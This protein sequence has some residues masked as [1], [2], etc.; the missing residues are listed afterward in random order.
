VDD[1]EQ[2]RRATRMM[3]EARG[4]TVTDVAGGHAALKLAQAGTEWEVAVLDMNMP[5]LNGTA[6]LTRLRALQPDLPVILATGYADE[7]LILSLDAV[8]RVV[9]LT[10]P[11]SF[12][13]FQSAWRALA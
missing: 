13:E 5:D 8:E 10:K 6:T 11:F 9:L 12:Q 3:L 7:E 1:D 4:H 2:V